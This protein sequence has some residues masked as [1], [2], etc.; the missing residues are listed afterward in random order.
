VGYVAD[1]GKIRKACKFWLKNLKGRKCLEDLGKDGIILEWMLDSQGGK[2][3][4]G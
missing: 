4:Y 3:W 2:V 1:M